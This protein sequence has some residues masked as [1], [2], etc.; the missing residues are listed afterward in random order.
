MPLPSNMVSKLGGFAEFII[1]PSFVWIWCGFIGL[2]AL[3]WLTNL[4]WKSSKIKSHLR[5]VLKVLASFKNTGEMIENFNTVHGRFIQSSTLTTPW[6][7]YQHSLLKIFA[8]QNK[9][10]GNVS[11]A[12]QYKAIRATRDSSE[13]FCP[14][15]IIY[16]SIDQKLYAAI[17]NHLSGMGILGTFCGLSCGIYLARHGLAGGAMH[18]IQHGLAQLLSGASLAFWT[19]IVG[20][21]TSIVFSRIERNRMAGMVD[22]IAKLNHTFGGLIQTISIEQLTNKQLSQNHQQNINLEKIV[23]SLKIIYQDRAD[24]NEKVLKQIAKEFHDTLTESSGKEIKYIATAF[25]K[26]H[27]GLRETKDALNSSGKYLLDSVEASTKMFKK[28]LHELSHQFQSNFHLTNESV[29]QTFKDSAKDIHISLQKSA[30][31]MSDA[32]RKPAHELGQSFKI[33][34]QQIQIT[35]ENISKT[36]EQNAENTKKV[37]ES[38][39]KLSEFINPLIHAAHAISKACNEAQASLNM[40]SSAAIKISEAVK[41]MDQINR[42]TKNSWEAYCKR[43]EGV[44]QN[45]NHIFQQTNTS[46]HSYS[47]KVKGFTS[48]LD[49]HMSKGVVTLAGAVGDLNQA[50]T[51]LPEA[52]KSV[53]KNAINLNEKEKITYPDTRV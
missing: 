5:D 46:L 23:Q 41:H 22:L 30:F 39:A 7:A 6:Q 34:Q 26:I 45:L 28:N 47:E 13:F 9:E 27:E 43:F 24:A 11:K 3:K 12:A 38:H 33:L 42:Q 17:P 49:K 21:F 40:S 8:E 50:I 14:Q 44:D 53:R 20:I 10:S 18:E 19:S 15:T 48:E 51:S 52:I 2:Y 37:M 31:E 36:S 29:Q 35:G 32:I 16:P 25:Q 4:Y 1:S